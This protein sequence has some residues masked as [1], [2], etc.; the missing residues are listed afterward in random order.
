[1]HTSSNKTAQVCYYRL[2]YVERAGVKDDEVGDE[3]P[4]VKFQGVYLNIKNLALVY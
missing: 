4:S 1:M 3:R 2:P